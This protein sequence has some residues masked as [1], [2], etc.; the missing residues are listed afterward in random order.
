MIKKTNNFGSFFNYFLGIVRHPKVVNLV[1]SPQQTHK[2]PYTFKKWSI[3][4][5]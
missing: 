3:K 5:L 2:K 1:Y 4:P